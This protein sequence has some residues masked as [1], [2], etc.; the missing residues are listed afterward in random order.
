MVSV[1]FPLE[2]KQGTP[3]R[4]LVEIGG[5]DSAKELRFPISAMG[6]EL[7]LSGNGSAA[8]FAAVESKAEG[9]YLHTFA[10]IAHAGV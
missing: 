8:V 3:N 2:P 7:F 4:T 10:A 5:A 6:T 1:A 9:Q